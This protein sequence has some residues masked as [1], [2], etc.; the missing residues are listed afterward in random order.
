MAILSERPGRAH[1]RPRSARRPVGGACLPGCHLPAARYQQGRDGLGAEPLRDLR[2]GIDVGFDQFDL[3]RQVAGELP[4][5]GLTMRQGP[6]QGA[7]RSTMTGILATSAMPPKVV[8]SAPVIHGSGRWHLPQQGVP[9]AAAPGLPV[10]SAC[11]GSARW[12]WPHYP[13]TARQL[14][15]G[16]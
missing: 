7:H 6:H 1:S 13:A 11:S 12:P 8:S 4:G 14:A 10:R 3:A 2:R 5:R 9:A 16:S 15:F